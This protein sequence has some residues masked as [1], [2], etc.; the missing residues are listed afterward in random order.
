MRVV[1]RLEGG[2]SIEDIGLAVEGVIDYEGKQ[3]EVDDGRGN[4][5]ALQESLENTGME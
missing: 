3:E 4:S 5:G 1:I 2:D